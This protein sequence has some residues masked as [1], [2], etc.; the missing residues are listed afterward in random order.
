LG[1]VQLHFCGPKSEE[2]VVALGIRDDSVIV[3]MFVVAIFQVLVC[4]C[5][6][7]GINCGKVFYTILHLNI[8]TCGMYDM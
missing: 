4:G 5:M 2:T 1:F 8:K 7:S 3:A 6:R